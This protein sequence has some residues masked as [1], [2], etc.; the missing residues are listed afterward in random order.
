MGADNY[1]LP[2]GVTFVKDGGTGSTSYLTLGS[3]SSQLNSS[4]D[5]NIT[6]FY[7]RTI[8]T[9]ATAYLTT[10][11]PIDPAFYDASVSGGTAPAPATMPGAPPPLVVS[12]TYA[13][14][15]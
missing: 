2:T 9:G 8:P 1:P 5:I 4:D 3:A 15:P 6:N 13:T 14:G 11:G 12:F 10:S 7:Y